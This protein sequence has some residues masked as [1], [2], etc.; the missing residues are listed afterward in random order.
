MYGTLTDGAEKLLK[1]ILDQRN[2]KGAV[3]VMHF[4]E[5]FNQMDYQEDSLY[6]SC[7]KELSD[8]DLINTHWADNGPIMITLTS[9]GIEYFDR[10]KKA[11]KEERKDKRRS[12][13]RDILMAA[14]GA[15]FGGIVTFLL[16][17]IFG[18][19]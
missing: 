1:E 15:V 10:K 3:N 19:G 5:K 2:E 11:E 7:F 6:R 8:N 17:K 18:I 12:I 13:W 4:I 9:S 14:I 16:F